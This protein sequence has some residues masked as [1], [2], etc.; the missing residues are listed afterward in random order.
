MIMFVVIA[1]SADTRDFI[2]ASLKSLGSVKSA[3][4][5]VT[6]LASLGELPAALKQSLASGILVEVA[7]L[8]KASQRDKEATRQPFEVYPSAKFKLVGTDVMVL[9]KARSIDEFVDEC[10]Q[11]NPRSIRRE[12]RENRHFAVHLSADETFMD[13]EKVVTINI[14]PYGCFVYSVR[15]WSI[16]D[17]VWL[18][19]IDHD[20]T[21]CGTILSHLPWGNDKFIPGIGIKLDAMSTWARDPGP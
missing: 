8:I 18:R 20:V 7:T 19:L 3:E 5:E 6:E 12:S 10:L 16:G 17:R 9:G 2:S 13:V 14:S 4:I 11:F 21:V 1:S 15:E